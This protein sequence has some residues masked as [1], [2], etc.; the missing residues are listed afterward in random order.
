M[1]KMLKTAAETCIGA[2]ACLAVC[3][4]LYLAMRGMGAG[5]ASMHRFQGTR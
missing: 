4:F 2:M 5:M 3:A 1:L